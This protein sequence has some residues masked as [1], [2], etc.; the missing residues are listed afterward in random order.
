MSKTI[1]KNL[2]DELIDGKINP[3]SSLL[4]YRIK[5]YQSVES[6]D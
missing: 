6:L 4:V 2:L 1:C 5:L 3:W